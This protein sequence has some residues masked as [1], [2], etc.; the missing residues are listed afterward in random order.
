MELKLK[1]GGIGSITTCFSPR[2]PKEYHPMRIYGTKGAVHGNK[3]FLEKK[4]RK[5][6]IF[7]F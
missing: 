4:I 1:N 5:D 3:I 7:F 6:L 2:V